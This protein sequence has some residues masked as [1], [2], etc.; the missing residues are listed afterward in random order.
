M[1]MLVQGVGCYFA[2][3]PM[4]DRMG[5][6]KMTPDHIDRQVRI[7]ADFILSA[8]LP[9]VQD[10]RFEEGGNTDVEKDAAI[11]GCSDC[12]PRPPREEGDMTTI[13][14]ANKDRKSVVSGKSVSVRVDLGGSR[15][16]KQK[17][18]TQVSTQSCTLDTKP[19]ID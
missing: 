10:Q 12:Q 11:V 13:T 2:S 8:L 4:L 14:E 16:I 3:A 18:L 19:L 15:I 7:F 17:Q 6:R 9:D 1:A 5:V